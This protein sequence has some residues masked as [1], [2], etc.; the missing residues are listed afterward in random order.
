MAQWQCWYVQYRVINLDKSDEKTSDQTKE[1]GRELADWEEY[2][3][4]VTLVR[5]KYIPPLMEHFT[6]LAVI[7]KKDIKYEQIN[8]EHWEK[9]TNDLQRQ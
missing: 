1:E 4:I 2:D 5:H 9:V 8:N 7:S 6:D 3:L